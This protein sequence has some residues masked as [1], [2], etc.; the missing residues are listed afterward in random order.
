MQA[1]ESAGYAFVKFYLIVPS[2]LIN[3]IYALGPVAAPLLG[4]ALAV[5]I[6]FIF[7]RDKKD[8]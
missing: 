4:L 8:A 7:L 2:L 1:I 3:G 5:S 6:P